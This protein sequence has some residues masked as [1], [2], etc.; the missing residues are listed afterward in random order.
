MIHN[1]CVNFGICPDQLFFEKHIERMGHQFLKQVPDISLDSEIVAIR[2]GWAFLAD[3]SY[4][5]LQMGVQS[6]NKL[7][8]SFGDLVSASN[9]FSIAIFRQKFDNFVTAFFLETKKVE[10]VSHDAGGI[11][12]AAVI[13]GRFLIT[14]GTDCSVRIWELPNFKLLRISTLHSDP[15]IA[16]CGCA[17]NGVVVSLDKSGLLIA[18][19]L[20]NGKF[21]CSTEVSINSESPMIICFKSGLISVA[22]ITNSISTI[23]VFDTKLS[24]IASTELK[25]RITEFH[26]ISDGLGGEFIAVSFES[27]FIIYEAYSLRTVVSFEA[28]KENP[29][30]C[31]VRRHRS[32]ICGDGK[33]IRHFLF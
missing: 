23:T 12:S 10:T 1:H 31:A 11:R 29:H 25:G 26:K 13:G 33:V 20:I 7:P 32:L 17:D 15:V 21:I 3:G 8:D 24:K 18:E 19:T 16:V 27:S 2:K 9:L 6:A 14:G 4:F 28:E 30:L 5:M 22:D